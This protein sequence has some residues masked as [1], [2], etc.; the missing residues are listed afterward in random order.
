M[1]KKAKDNLHKQWHQE[2]KLEDFGK[3]LEK[4]NGLYQTGWCGSEECEIKLKRYK[5]TIRCLLDDQVHAKCFAC[6]KDS[7]RD[8]L[9]AKEY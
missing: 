3:T 9:V 5:G 4:E 7:K 2:D 8:I 6:D 1:F